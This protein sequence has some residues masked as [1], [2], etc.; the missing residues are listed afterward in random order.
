MVVAAE[1]R[2]RSWGFGDQPIRRDGIVLSASRR[3]RH[4]VAGARRRSDV[5][6]CHACQRVGMVAYMPTIGA[7]DHYDT[8]VV[9][10]SNNPDR[11]ASE[12]LSH[13]A[14]MAQCVDRHLAGVLASGSRCP[15]EQP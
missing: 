11:D 5:E 4:H 1:A 6:Q 13:N 9:V 15:R 8:G 2:C 10:H 7:L 12:Q 3:D 14:G